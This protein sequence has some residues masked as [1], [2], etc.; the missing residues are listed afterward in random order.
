MSEEITRKKRIRAG[1]K[2]S[3]SKV[4][5][6]AKADLDS[7]D[8]DPLKLQ[9]QRQ[10]LKEK[11]EILRKLDSEI[12]D[13]TADENEISAEIEQT[14]EFNGDLE[15]TILTLDKALDANAAT[16]DTLQIPQGNQITATAGSRTADRAAHNSSP[17]SQH[18]NDTT[19][20]RASSPH[21]APM[22]GTTD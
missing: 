19:S 7:N 22:T 14:D 13:L 1:H 8:R 9:Q 17:S 4:I 12:L 21:G 2:A 16:D 18:S 15:L 6:Q 3:V 20:T 10:K 5:G 11:L